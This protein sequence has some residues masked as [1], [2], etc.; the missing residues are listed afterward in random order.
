MMQ[1]LRLAF[2]SLLNSPGFALVAFV[3]VALAIGA[4]TAVFSLINALLIRPLPYKSPN[5]LVLLWEKFSGQGL[6][7]IPVSAPE[8]NDYT[9]TLKSMEIGG[10]DY[11]DLN[12][13]AGEMPERV[14]GAVVTSSVFSVL[15]IQ[16][17]KGR[18][19]TP[20]EFGEGNDNVVVISERLWKRRFDSDPQII[21]RQLSINGRSFTVVGMMPES[22]QFPLPLFNIQGGTFGG[23]VDIWKP[24]AFSKN[25]LESRGSR[26]YGIV[27]RLRP[28]VSLG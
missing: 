3:T 17:N 6:D 1:D 22:F 11:I 5:E 26:S 21:G 2:R 10:F 27:G 19:F 25:E 9:Q 24:I 8:Y 12:L 14:P 16:P 4:N 7:R 23:K 28:N 15:G 18:V 20:E 13:T